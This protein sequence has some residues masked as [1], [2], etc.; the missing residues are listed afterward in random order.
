[1]SFLLFLK[2]FCELCLCYAVLG[3]FPGLF[4]AGYSFLLP[5]VLGAI[6]VALA[7]ALNKSGRK[8]HRSG[9]IILP[10][11]TLIFCNNAA[12]IIPL[13]PAMLC[14]AVVIL[15]ESFYLEYYSFQTT[16]RKCLIGFGIYFVVIL[17]LALFEEAVPDN[18]NI[19][20]YQTAAFYGILFASSGVLLQR[21]LR[22]G[23]ENDSKE[24]VRKKAFYC[25]LTIALMMG[26]V[27]LVNILVH[28][29]VDILMRLITNTFGILIG[30]LSWLV[31]L[32]FGK[33]PLVPEPTETVLPTIGTEP[34]YT[35][36]LPTFSGDPI[37]KPDV[38]QPISPWL[39]T[40]LIVAAV[41]M[42]LLFLLQT[43]QKNGNN[44]VFSAKEE[45]LES[46][47]KKKAITKRSNRSKIRHYYRQ[48]LR[49]ERK[50]GLKYTTTQ[51][52]A[53]ILASVSPLTNRAAAAA[54]REE[55]LHARYDHATDITDAQ[56]ARA[57][58]A[59]KKIRGG[60]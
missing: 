8:I 5:A 23:L 20:D 38:T 22:L 40:V 13:I 55:Y 50:K 12:D 28:D 39:P 37:P 21:Q 25:L 1:M 14:C 10:L 6:A 59:L 33:Q 31:M 19:T 18:R 27:W 35:T 48:F 16:F 34:Q 49:F 3:S 42:L 46:A 54:L 57:K 41:V 4:Y 56:V 44:I 43:Y 7:A 2:V 17:T 45:N 15:R 58:S 51:T 9:C 36:P 32:F 30:A 53:D 52:S 29:G 26:A 60:S 47:P 11:L 24:L